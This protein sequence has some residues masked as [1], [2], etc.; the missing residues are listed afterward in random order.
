MF[1]APHLFGFNQLELEAPAC[2]SDEG[3]V[4]GIVQQRHQELP[5]L[6]GSPALIGSMRAVSMVTL[7][8]E[9]PVEVGL[10]VQA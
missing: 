8:V 7:Q 1:R 5:Q 9:I 2:P 10:D 6:Q 3:S 4:G